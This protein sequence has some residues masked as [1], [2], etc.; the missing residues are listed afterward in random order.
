M[1]HVWKL[2]ERGE[3][4]GIPA[5]AQGIFVRATVNF[6]KDLIQICHQANILF[7]QVVFY[8]LLMYI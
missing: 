1:H 3:E 8:P 4:G 6:F 5:A 2:L 7:K